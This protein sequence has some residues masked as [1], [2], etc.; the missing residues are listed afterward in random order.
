MYSWRWCSLSRDWW[1]DAFI[2]DIP[3]EPPFQDLLEPT[4]TVSNSYHNGKKFWEDLVRFFEEIGREENMDNTPEYLVGR[5]PDTMHFLPLFAYG[6][7]MPYLQTVSKP[8][9]DLMMRMLET[10]EDGPELTAGLRKLLEAKDCMVRAAVTGEL[11]K[12]P[13]GVR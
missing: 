7:L 11:G 9:H 6:H 1:E 4:R 10:L 5:H 3:I 13:L 2:M 8:F 12:N